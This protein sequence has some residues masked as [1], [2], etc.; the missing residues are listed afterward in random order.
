L[1]HLRSAQNDPKKWYQSSTLG[2]GEKRGT[3]PSTGPLSTEKVVT[4][5]LSPVS[6]KREICGG[7]RE[8]TVPRNASKK[9]RKIRKSAA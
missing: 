8:L 7:P 4:R 1:G 5:R 6:I 9:G 3:T 2:K